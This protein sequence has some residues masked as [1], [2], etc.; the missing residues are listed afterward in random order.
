MGFKCVF[1]SLERWAALQ[2]PAWLH[3]RHLFQ[4]RWEVKRWFM[5]QEYC[6][7]HRQQS[8]ERDINAVSIPDTIALALVILGLGWSWQKRAAIF[9][10]KGH[11]LSHPTAKNRWNRQGH[12]Q[13]HRSGDNFIARQSTFS[14]FEAVPFHADPHEISEVWYLLHILFSERRDSH[15]GQPTACI[16]WRYRLEKGRQEYRQIEETT[17]NIITL[18]TMGAYGEQNHT[19][20]NSRRGY[21]YY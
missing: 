5:C 8:P 10:T 11:A 20:Y 14:F 21:R 3:V 9:I 2:L 17:S 15:S 1:F 13:H 7:S 19:Y 4:H 18:N 12:I 6:S 16:L